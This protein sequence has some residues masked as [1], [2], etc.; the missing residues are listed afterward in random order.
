MTKRVNLLHKRARKANG[1]QT[2]YMR[3]TTVRIMVEFALEFRYN[4]VWY[5]IT[6]FHEP[7]VLL[8]SHQSLEILYECYAPSQKI[9][10]LT[11]FEPAQKRWQDGLS[12]FSVGNIPCQLTLTHRLSSARQNAP[13]LLCGPSG[14]QLTPAQY[15]DQGS[16]LRD[17]R[18]RGAI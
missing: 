11:G 10:S 12:P 7:Q 17:Q 16:L 8:Q 13:H 1:E 15:F 6:L 2:V 9:V 18:E 14:H 5:T 3:C 4:M